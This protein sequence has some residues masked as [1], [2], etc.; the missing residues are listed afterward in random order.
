M[1]NIIL[2][3]QIQKI[4]LKECGDDTKQGINVKTP[5]M[6]TANK[7]IRDYWPNL[8]RKHKRYT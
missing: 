7:F 4:L 6:F 3:G 2:N 5:Y 8:H 1:V